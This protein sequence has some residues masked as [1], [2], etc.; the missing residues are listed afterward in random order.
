L[1]EEQKNHLEKEIKKLGISFVI[2][3]LSDRFRVETGP[4]SQYP[5]LHDINKITW[6]ELFINQP[7]IQK[8]TTDYLSEMNKI[9][10]LETTQNQDQLVKYL[11]FP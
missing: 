11:K 8:L 9:L 4:K 7:A 2:E 5:D 3:K 6:A 10:D 1:T